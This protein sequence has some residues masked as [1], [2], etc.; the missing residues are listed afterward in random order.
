MY[1]DLGSANDDVNEPFDLDFHDGAKGV[2][3]FLVHRAVVLQSLHLLLLLCKGKHSIVRKHVLYMRTHSIVR[4]GLHLCL[5]LCTC[6]HIREYVVYVGE[7]MCIYVNGY[8]AYV[9]T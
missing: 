8:M 2:A 4:Q 5:L 7:Y 3:L 1:D 6:V 9:C